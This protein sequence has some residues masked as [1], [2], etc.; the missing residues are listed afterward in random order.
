MT[1]SR[2]GTVLII[3]A[4]VSALMLTVCLAFL[5]RMRL[6]ESEGRYL[7]GYT[8]ARV[9]LFAAASY[10][11]ESGR[12]GWDGLGSED[13]VGT[14]V[15][16]ESFGWVDVR[17]GELG[18]RRYRS[19]G[20]NY[21]GKGTGRFP[22][23]YGEAGRFPMHAWTLPPYAI[24][25]NATPN[26]VLTNV[27]S[28]ITPPSSSQT[29]HNQLWH[30]E[31]VDRGRKAW[32]AILSNPDP[33]PVG[34]RTDPASNWSF[35]ASD[36][37]R[38]VT[39]DQRPK[40]ESVGRSWFRIY[41]DGPDTFV[42]TCG[43]GGTL[44]FRD[45]ASVPIADRAASFANDPLLFESLQKSEIRLWYR[46][47]WS[48]AVTVGYRRSPAGNIV[49][50][51]STGLPPSHPARKSGVSAL[52]SLHVGMLNQFQ[53]MNQCGTIRWVQRLMAPPKNW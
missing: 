50:G 13:G 22:E 25:M 43:A 8:Q 16:R 12:I 37:A 33:W 39:G 26:P 47:A 7:A 40:A 36:Q 34:M 2:S 28:S 14:T 29:R 51:I 11:L 35:S 48:A 4:G 53:F 49:D 30:K 46:L 45:W 19:W 44:G 32:D 21:A 20:T 38:W 6:V 42:V 15:S 5:A 24:S 18:P 9:M 3:A 17:D 31:E 27:N 10:I 41:R 23:L 52:S 1:T